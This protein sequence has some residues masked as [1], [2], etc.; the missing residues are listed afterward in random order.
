LPG[1]ATEFY[2]HDKCVVGRE[3]LV[4]VR[5]VLEEWKGWTRIPSDPDEPRKRD[6]DF[7]QGK[8]VEASLA[9]R[10]LPARRPHLVR[11]ARSQGAGEVLHRE[12]A[13]LRASV[14]PPPRTGLRLKLSPAPPEPR[15]QH[16]FRQG[17]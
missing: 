4:R 13:A 9:V 7:A 2:A 12:L 14:E 11:L 6:L 16:L 5:A 15:V 3:V 1:P 17:D 8:P 10:T